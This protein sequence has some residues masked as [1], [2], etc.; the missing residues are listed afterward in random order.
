MGTKFPLM[1]FELNLFGYTKWLIYIPIVYVCVYAI[2]ILHIKIK[3]AHA[4]STAQHSTHPVPLIKYIIYWYY[5]YSLNCCSLYVFSYD[6][7]NRHIYQRQR[8]ERMVDV[9]AYRHSTPSDNYNYCYHLKCV[10]VTRC[11]K[12][13]RRVIKE[14]TAHHLWWDNGA[15]VYA[16]K[17]PDGCTTIKIDNNQNISS[18]KKILNWTAI[19]KFH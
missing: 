19:V 16:N 11:E 17:F 5:I 2:C 7:E 10:G 9:Q 1:F 3:H 13:E 12:F 14:D 15:I 4:Q 8:C 6:T 18:E